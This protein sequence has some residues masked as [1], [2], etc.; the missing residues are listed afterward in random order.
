[1]LQR[2]LFEAVKAHYE[3]LDQAYTAPFDPAWLNADDK[4]WL[5]SNPWNKDTT[6]STAKHR[7][8]KSLLQQNILHIKNLLTQGA[9]PIFETDGK[10]PIEYAKEKLKKI[11]EVEGTGTY[12]YAW[13]KE[14]TDFLDKETKSYMHTNHKE[15]IN[16]DKYPAK[17]RH[18]LLQ[19]KLRGTAGILASLNL[20]K[21][22]SVGKLK[23]NTGAAK[24][25][26]PDLGKEAQ[27][28]QQLQKTE[29]D[30]KWSL[31]STHN[32]EEKQE[33]VININPRSF[34]R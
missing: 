9:E 20:V 18:F 21:Y 24:L 4:K 17:V 25:I 26:N 27:L 34:R 32:S 23:I 12:R 5:E 22:D 1:M 28:F 19:E 7:H 16:D 33:S 13:Y 30:K 3:I 2:Q 6:E 14:F 10:L 8:I 29:T 11:G 31:D 15:I